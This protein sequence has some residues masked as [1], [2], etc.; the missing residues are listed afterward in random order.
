MKTTKYF[1]IALAAIA[2]LTA[3]GGSDDPDDP[4]NPG[5]QPPTPQ[6]GKYSTMKCDM[7]AEASEKTVTLTGLSSAITRVT[8]A[9]GTNWLTVTQQP[10]TSGTPKVTVACTQNPDKSQRSTD[11]VFIA[12]KD[13]LKLTV[14]QAAATAQGGTDI[15]K[16]NDTPTDQPAYSKPEG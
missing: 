12:A 6:Y 9:S 10:Y 1:F 4:Y 2:T 16:P 15:N 5:P 14:N 7:P 13:T 3:C 8:Q 11:V